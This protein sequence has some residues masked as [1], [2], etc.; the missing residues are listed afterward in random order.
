MLQAAPPTVAAP[1]VLS[2]VDY[3]GLQV[4]CEVPRGAEPWADALL[5][6]LLSRTGDVSPADARRVPSSMP[7]AHLWSSLGSDEASTVAPP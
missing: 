4:C 3:S 2:L 5:L 7:S 6:E 1:D